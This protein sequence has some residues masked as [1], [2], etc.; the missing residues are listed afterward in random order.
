MLRVVE[1]FSG[2]GSQAKALQKLGIEYK[3]V[4]TVERDIAAFYAYDIIH[5]G[6]QDLSEYQHLSKDELL[7]I[8]SKYGSL[9]AIQGLL[10]TRNIRRNAATYC[11]CESSC[12]GF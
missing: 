3:V 1:T 6:V 11:A 4:N 12:H 10:H 2:I 5:N 9:A 7:R 8:L